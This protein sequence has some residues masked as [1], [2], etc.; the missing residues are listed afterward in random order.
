MPG[1]K[2]VLVIDDDPDIIEIV[3]ASLAKEPYEILVA[4]DGEEGVKAARASK[5]DAIILDIMMPNK[6]GFTACHELKH[7]EKC[8]NIPIL[9]LTAVGQHFAT[10]RYA[11]SQGMS[12]ESEDYVEKPIDP[13]LLVERVRELMGE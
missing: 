8:K 3:K 13:K 2:K 7:D 1:K 5:P 10:T 4:Y 6:D 11:K 9:I 12:L